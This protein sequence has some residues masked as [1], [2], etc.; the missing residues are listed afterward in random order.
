MSYKPTD[1]SISWICL[2]VRKK[3]SQAERL[4]TANRFLPLE[5]WIPALAVIP[6]SRGSC[7]KWKWGK[8]AAR[9]CDT[10]CFRS[11]GRD[12]GPAGA[13]CFGHHGGVHFS[14]GHTCNNLISGPGYLIS[15]SSTTTSVAR[16]Y[17]AIRLPA[18]D[19]S[20]P[21]LEVRAG[22]SREM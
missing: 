9:R 14:S 5:E 13:V 21:L 10:L 15:E 8:G 4:Q 12:G 7:W 20:S 6:A 19:G 3:E 22:V 16:T 2:L 1:N 11:A 18:V 17:S